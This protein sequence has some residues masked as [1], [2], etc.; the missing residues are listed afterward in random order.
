MA[1]L[2]ISGVALLVSIATAWLSLFRRGNFA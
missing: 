2:L 1:S